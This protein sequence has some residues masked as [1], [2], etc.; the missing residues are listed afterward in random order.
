M[1]AK[2]I[3]KHLKLIS[4]SEGSSD[5]M[6]LYSHTKESCEK[7]N[8]YYDDFLESYSIL[9]EKKEKGNKKES[10][11]DESLLFMESQIQ[12]ISRAMEVMAE[13]MGDLV[14]LEDDD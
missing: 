3:K 1:I 9:S 6:R 14:V 5:T 7:L 8:N 12:N 2:L 10:E 4:L 13:E 11:V